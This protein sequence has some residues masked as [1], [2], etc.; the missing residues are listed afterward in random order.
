MTKKKLK[1]T[2]EDKK[3]E[4]LQ[5]NATF[6]VPVLDGYKIFE[7]LNEL[8]LENEELVLENEKLRNEREELNK[9]IKKYCSLYEDITK[10]CT[11]QDS[12]MLSLESENI[13]LKDENNK[14]KEELFKLKEEFLLIKNDVDDLKQEKEERIQKSI[15]RE[16][17]FQLES[18]IIQHCTNGTKYEDKIFKFGE[19]SKYIDTSETSFDSTIK[20]KYD[21]ITNQF[22]FT[23]THSKVMK[24]LK[25]LRL[26]DSHPHPSTYQNKEIT[27]DVVDTIAK[28]RKIKSYGTVKEMIKMLEDLRKIDGNSF[29]SFEF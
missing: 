16:L 6:N 25:N 11:N 12:K 3:Q 13:K 19:L 4:S 21:D 17:A 10:R 27:G 9:E 22:N 28:S 20:K 29:F 18:T 8:K 5:V 2:H 24:A 15:L 23:K 26:E 7:Q 1:K 14:L